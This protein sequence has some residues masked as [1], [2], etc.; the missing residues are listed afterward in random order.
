MA[1]GSASGQGRQMRFAVGAACR[2]LAFRSPRERPLPL[3]LRRR[4]ARAAADRADRPAHRRPDRRPRHLCRPLGLLRR[5]RRRRRLLGLRR[6]AA[7]RG[8]GARS[9]TASA[10]SAICAPPTWRCRA[11]MRAASST[12]GSASPAATTPI[13]WEPEVVARRVIAWLSQTPLILD[14]CDF[15]FYRRFMRSLTRQVRYL[16][17]IAYDGAARPAAPARHDRAR[18]RRAVDVRPAALPQAGARA[19]STSNWSARS[20]PTAATS[21]AIPAPSSSC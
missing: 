19:G 3:A 6:R 15:N 16:R 13:A 12:S 18:R 8:L 2:A 14:G 1:I 11:P 21:A 20:C 5:R 9:C 4:G 10:G 7:E 17:R